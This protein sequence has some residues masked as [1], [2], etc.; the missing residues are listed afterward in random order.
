LFA[1][2]G[3]G[4]GFGA[5][6]NQQYDG[7]IGNNAR[8]PH[9]QVLNALFVDNADSTATFSAA[10][11]NL[12]D[13]AHTLTSAEA[14]TADGSAVALTFAAPRELK[15][16]TYVHPGATGDIILTGKFPAGGFVEI[17]LNFAGAAPVTIDAP[18]VT[19][20]DTYESVAIKAATAPADEPAAEATPAS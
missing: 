19:R 16:N 7:G 10:L 11:L 14:A 8:G 15:P 18:V 17:T 2:S 13:T 1:L 12:D 5:Q 4:T 6:T 20:T 9:V 3:C